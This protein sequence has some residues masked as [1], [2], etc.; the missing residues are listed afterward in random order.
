MLIKNVTMKQACAL[1]N[2][3][4]EYRFPVV[5][6]YQKM[7]RW[8]VERMRLAGKT[9]VV[10]GGSLLL[11]QLFRRVYNAGCRSDGGDRCVL[12]GECALK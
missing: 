4:G 9:R 12:P 7:R 8:Q 2:F 11:R 6:R 3:T 1:D 10:R 5:G